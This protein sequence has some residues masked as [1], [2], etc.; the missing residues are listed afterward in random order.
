[1]CQGLV[2]HA[3]NCFV[4]LLVVLPPAGLVYLLGEWGVLPAQ[5]V[6]AAEWVEY[7]FLLVILVIFAFGTIKSILNGMTDG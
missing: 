3:G 5:I 6:K 2:K 7:I 1:M 4:A